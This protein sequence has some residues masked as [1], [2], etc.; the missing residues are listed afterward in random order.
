MKRKIRKHSHK[1]GFI[2]NEHYEGERIEQ[3]VARVIENNEPIKDG[4]PLI[5]TERK[6]G[7]LPQFDIRTDKWEIAQSAM[8][9]ANKAKIAKGQEITESRNRKNTEEEKP[10]KEDKKEP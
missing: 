7:V 1:V 8:D 9:A 2:V 4:A 5:Y 3:K 6:D 10:S